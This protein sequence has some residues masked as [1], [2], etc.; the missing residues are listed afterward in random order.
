[1][2]RYGIT[3]PKVHVLSPLRV[4]QGE[5]DPAWERFCA[6]LEQ[7]SMAGQLARVRRYNAL[8]TTEQLAR[9]LEP[10]RT[11]LQSD[12]AELRARL[13]A[14]PIELDGSA[15]MEVDRRLDLRA[16]DVE[17]LLWE[18]VGRRWHGPGG[19]A[20]RSGGLSSLGL[21][22]SAWLARRNPLLAAGTAIGT[23]AAQKVQTMGRDRSMRDASEWL[24]PEGD[25]QRQMESALAPLRLSQKRLAGTWPALP[26]G[27]RL[28]NV[29]RR[30][31]EEGIQ[32]LLDGELLEQADKAARRPWR[33]LVDAPVYAFGLWIVWLAVVGFVRADYVGMDFLV[34]AA[35]LAGAWLWIARFATRALLRVRAR[36]LVEGVRTAIR[37]RVH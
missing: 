11:T 31:V 6:D 36:G 8:G 18:E 1:T 19:M 23:L 24:P 10:V 35:L 37:T 29:L 3:D 20:L 17:A 28:R 27:E 7:A 33:W 26:D 2:D 12:L 13:D 5:A 9:A 22:A 4:V 14:W 32:Q 30:S 16:R 21:G 15:L 25:L 34:N